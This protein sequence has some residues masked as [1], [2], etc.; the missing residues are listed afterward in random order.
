L[1]P[2]ERKRYFQ[3]IVADLAQGARPQGDLFTQFD[4]YP[5]IERFS[6]EVDKYTVIDG[7]YFYFDLP[8]TPS[9]FPIGADRRTLPLFVSNRHQTTIRTEVDLPS[10]FPKIAIAPK[11]GVLNGPGGSGVAHIASSAEGGKLV[12]SYDLETSPA[13]VEPGDYPDMLKLES[14]LGNRSS[15]VFLLEGPADTGNPR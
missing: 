7:R 14:I 11:A 15:R 3:E 6:V 9:L 5:G 10:A 2:E 12:V 4:V 1:P 8:F 13:I